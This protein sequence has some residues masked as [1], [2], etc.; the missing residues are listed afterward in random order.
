MANFVKEGD[1]VLLLLA[2]NENKDVAQTLIKEVEKNNGS[3][4]KILLVRSNELKNRKYF[5]FTIII[6]LVIFY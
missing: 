1:K 6:F 4:E 2:P 5:F 3:C